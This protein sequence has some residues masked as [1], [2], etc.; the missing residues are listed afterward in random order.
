MCEASC[1]IAISLPKCSTAVRGE[2]QHA[3][4]LAARQ[5]FIFDK[6]VPKTSITYL[7]VLCGRTQFINISLSSRRAD[8]FA[9]II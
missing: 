3:G 1:S 5:E 8:C 4:H 6:N 2:S 9:D 7:G